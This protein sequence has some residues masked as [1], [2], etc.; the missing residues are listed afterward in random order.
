MYQTQC[1]Q[2]SGKLYLSEVHATFGPGHVPIDPVIGTNFGMDDIYDCPVEVA[3][4]GDCG[5]EYNLNDLH[6]ELEGEVIWIT[7]PAEWLH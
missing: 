6:Q 3:A 5:A 2:C 4:C 7:Q 1:P